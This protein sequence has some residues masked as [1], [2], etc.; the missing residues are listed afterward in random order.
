MAAAPQAVS[1]PTATAERLG[2]VTL[3]AVAISL[4]L[5]F[6]IN[7]AVS[8]LE[9]VVGRYIASGIPPIP[10]VLILSLLTA[11]AP[12]AQRLFRRQ[13]LSRQEILAI[14]CLLLIAVPFCGTYGVRS[15]LPR[16]TVLQYYAMPENRFADYVHHLPSW[17]APESMKVIQ[18]MYEGSDQPVPW[19]AWLGP[20]SAWTLFFL[21]LFLT[22]LCL[23]SIFWKQWSQAERLPYPLVQLPMEMAGS[24]RSQGVLRNFFTNPLTWIGIFLAFVY[25]ALSIAHAFNPAIP[26][27][28]QSKS[29]DDLLTEE[30]WTALRPLVLNTYPGSIGFGYLVSQEL[31]A[32]VVVFTFATKFLGVGAHMVGYEPPDFPYWQEQSAGGYVALALFM[33]YAARGHLRDVWRKA[34]GYAPV[35]DSYEAV[36]YRWSVLGLGAG[37]VF[38]L[39]WCQVSGMSL[40]LALP[41][42]LVVMLFAL[43]YARIR[44]EAGVPQDFVYPYRLPQYIIINALGP[45][46]MLDLGGTRS[47]VILEVMSFLSRFHPTQ[48]MTAFQTDI[49]EI[50]HQ[51]RLPRRR[52]AAVMILVFL[53]GLGFAFW[54]H[55]TTFYSLGLNVLEGNP[56]NADWRTFDTVGA[57]KDMVTRIETPTGPNTARTAWTIGGG[58]FTLAMALARIVWL[59][60]PLHPL[61]YV[62]A[63]AYGPSTYLWFAFLLVFLIK[64]ALLKVGGIG[65]YRR[66]IPL[67]IGLVVGH[68]LFGGV[69]W[70]IISLFHDSAISQRY[71]TVF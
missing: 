29:L 21:F 1:S 16:L 51:G 36:P 53:A 48:I 34:W 69:A 14:Y 27:I 20:L 50:S 6:L 57:F 54:G 49:L 22:T 18:D 61:G 64:W 7:L 32:S 46:T 56:R 28:E 23:M 70:P 9:L 4:V 63:L 42:F 24:P 38:F 37:A 11:F 35:D 10:V 62:V 39:A 31:C 65:S 33:L 71:Y 8:R 13:A 40:A 3:R 17:Y 25:N 68:Y 67:F 30:P 19:H 43:T 26:Y 2:G 47:I 58:L 45:R 15:F 59:R 55:F 44:A 12:L 60:F 41:F 5:L 52:L 66:L